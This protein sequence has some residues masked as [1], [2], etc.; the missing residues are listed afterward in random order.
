MTPAEV[1]AQSPTI[2]TAENLGAR[3]SRILTAADDA[4]LGVAAETCLEQL[5]RF[6][7]TDAAFV[8]VLDERERV[9]EQWA[10]DSSGQRPGRSMVGAPIEE[11]AGSAAGFLQIGKPFAVSYTHLR[12]V[13]DE[14]HEVEEVMAAGLG[15]ELTA[16]RLR[17]LALAARSLLAPDDAGLAEG[18]T[19]VGNQLETALT[20]RCV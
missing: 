13:L 6:A 5:G 7:Q 1:G 11:I 15:V 2:E 19:D 17:A 9:A 10:W 12:L 16:G 18:L 14:A 3:L 4:T 8:A 20:P